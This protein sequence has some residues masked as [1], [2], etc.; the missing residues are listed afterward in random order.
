MCR[1]VCS[2]LFS[3]LHLLAFAAGFA[4]LAHAQVT[5]NFRGTP[6]AS[7]NGYEAGQTYTLMITLDPDVE[8]GTGSFSQWAMNLAADLPGRDTPLFTKIGGT[9]VTGSYTL[10]LSTDS[11]YSYDS[12]TNGISIVAFSPGTSLLW[13]QAL[14]RPGSLRTA[15][16]A[17]DIDLTEMYLRMPFVFAYT[18]PMEQGPSDYFSAYEGSYQ[19]DPDSYFALRNI[20]EGTLYQE[21]TIST[22]V[23]TNATSAV[24]E[25]STYALIIGASAMA[26]AGLRRR[27][28]AAC[29]G[30]P[31]A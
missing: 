7:G 29:G 8:A 27:L 10:P 23:I 11:T 3:S 13:I 26:W 12:G 31:V 22:L 18:R 19:I 20:T 21:F 30:D 28:Q 14:G 2:P 24:P 5:F 1:A 16:G 4:G 17:I 9:M 15:D 6:T 25:P